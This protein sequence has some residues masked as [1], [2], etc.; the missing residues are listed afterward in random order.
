MK[1]VILII[2]D[3]W[4][5]AP[6]GPGNIP[7]QAGIPTLRNIGAYYPSTTIHASGINVG[8][9][10]WE[11]GNSEVGHLTMGSGQIIYQYLPRIVS[12]IQDGS[13]FQNPAFLGATDHVRREKSRLHLIGLIS[14]GAIH[15]YI[16]HLYALLDLC[17][18]EHVQEIYIHVFTDGRDASPK[19]AS[20]FLQH[21]QQ[22]I[23][24]QKTGRI[25]TVSGR[26][27]AMDRDKNWDRIEKTY[28]CL[29]E[30]EGEDASNLIS[31][32]KS[33]YNQGVT[34]EF[35]KPAVVDPQGLIQD[36]D[37]I[38][39]FNFRRER[40]RQLTL[41]FI[42]ED[43]REFNRK[44]IRN[45]YFAGM[46]RYLENPDVPTAFDPPVINNCLGKVISGA[47]FPQFRVA[48]TEKYAHVTYF[49]NGLREKPFSGEERKIIPSEGGPHYDKRPEMQAPV[50]TEKV[51]EQIESGKYHFILINLANPDMVGHTGNIKAAI[52]AAE[53]VDH[54]IEKIIK[55][56]LNRYVIM[57]T[58]DHG[59]FEEMI[60]PRTGEVI[61]EHSSNPVPFYLVDPDFKKTIAKPMKL[62][63][64]EKEGGFIFDIAPTILE[65]LELKQ[66]KEM[67]GLSLL[68]A[69]REQKI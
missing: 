46:T 57:I 40:A 20:V 12:A 26:S 38:I 45:L 22:R 48:E 68:P 50:I 19:E 54:S 52:K 3:G 58:A 31:Y 4:G 32:L 39:F 44:K 28:K 55:S 29:T 51:I 9:P 10:W 41:A 42:K 25:A 43:F 24:L 16:D 14:S 59:N 30:G 15:S 64:R 35:I 7:S 37:A 36:N 8:L 34:D 21:L 1:K 27:F 33:S 49:F 67:V 47:G 61:T 5:I 13:F 53:T 23:S 60:N 6:P 56:A 17:K 2:M 11:E 65:Y 69:F 62:E 66:P 63:Y 18:R